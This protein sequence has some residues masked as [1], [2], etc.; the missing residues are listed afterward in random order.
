MSNNALGPWGGHEKAPLR[1]A[2]GSTTNSSPAPVLWINPTGTEARLAK[3]TSSQGLG[4][5]EQQTQSGKLQRP[6]HWQSQTFLGAVSH[7][8]FLPNHLSFQRGQLHFGLQVLPVCPSFLQN[9]P[10]AH[11]ILR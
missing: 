11:P 3:A 8:S 7:T 10:L 2:V 5:A 6:P 1:S 9:K 4:T